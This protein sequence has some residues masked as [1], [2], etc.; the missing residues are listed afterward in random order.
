[1]RKGISTEGTIKQTRFPV[2]QIVLNGFTGF[3]GSAITP[4]GAGNTPIVGENGVGAD[5]AESRRGV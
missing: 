5:M 3:T 2:I 4:D 1:M